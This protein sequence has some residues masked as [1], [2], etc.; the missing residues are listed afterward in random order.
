MLLDTTRGRLAFDRV[1]LATGLAVDWSQRPEFAA[2][3]PH[4]Q[5]WRDR[6]LP[7]DRAPTTRKPSIP[8]SARTFEFMPREDAPSWVNRIHCFNY[9]A[10]MSH[11]PISGDI[12][13]ISLGAERTARGVV[14]ELFAEDYA[15][16]WQRLAGWSNPELRG[17]E[18]VLDEDVSKFLADEPAEAKT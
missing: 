11:G 16:T 14:N 1:I 9:A 13:A 4:V 12:P 2:L 18:Y 7:P 3:K 10:T 17:D 6:I 5:L 8:I 15:R